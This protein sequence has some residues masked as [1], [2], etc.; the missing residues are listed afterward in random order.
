MRHL[1]RIFFMR[2]FNRGERVNRQW[3]LI[4]S[5]AKGV[6]GLF[7]LLGLVGCDEVSNQMQKWQFMGTNLGIDRCIERNQQV[8]LRSDV[9]QPLCRAQNVH[10]IKP[11]YEA[12]AGYV[13][14]SE[15]MYFSGFI[16]NLSHDRIITS[17][18]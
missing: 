9:V 8:S 3:S 18:I 15:H 11:K 12:R 7:I 5:S 14:V 16:T 2:R 4:R 13:D 17:F 6:S 1:Q 10:P